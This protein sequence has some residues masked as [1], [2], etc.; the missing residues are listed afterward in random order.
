M[1]E[2]ISYLVASL[3]VIAAIAFI[4]NRSIGGL[5]PHFGENRTLPSK[6]AR[7][8]T[9]TTFLALAGAFTWM[10]LNAKAVTLWL[11]S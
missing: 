8:V 5:K 10:G 11:S 1:F 9:G 3:L 6:A 4:S 2:G 7:V